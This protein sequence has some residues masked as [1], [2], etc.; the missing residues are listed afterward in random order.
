MCVRQ[1]FGS[2]CSP[3]SVTCPLPRRACDPQVLILKPAFDC[4][5]RVAE[6]VVGSAMNGKHRRSAR[7]LAELHVSHRSGRLDERD[8]RLDRDQ[9][10]SGG[11]IPCQGEPAIANP[12]FMQ[13]GNTTPK[14]SAS[15]CDNSLRAVWRRTNRNGMGAISLRSMDS[16][17]MDDLRGTRLSGKWCRRI[18]GPALSTSLRWSARAG[19]AAP[20]SAWTR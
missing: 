4:G 8:T 9:S 15:V 2:G 19:F 6:L 13:C 14:H 3:G 16:N 12:A 20:A 18:Q 17:D 7:Q 5:M 1:S 11:R 10:G